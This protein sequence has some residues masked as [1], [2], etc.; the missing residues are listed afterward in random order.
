[1]SRFG[2]ERLMITKRKVA[3]GMLGLA[4]IATGL[5]DVWRASRDDVYYRSLA[6]E[7]VD[8]AGARTR[9]EQV[10]AL[11]DDLRARIAQEGLDPDRRPF[12]RPSARQTLESGR[13]YC[14][15]TCRA[16]IRL[17]GALGLRTQRVNLYGRHD[18]VVV[19]MFLGPTTSYLVDPHPDPVS[20]PYFDARDRTLDQVLLPPEPFAEDYSNINVRRV[21]VLG[22]FL[23]RVRTRQGWLTD[24]LESPMRMKAVLFIGAGGAILAALLVDSLLLLLY[25]RRLRGLSRRTASGEGASI[26]PPCARPRGSGG[27][28]PAHP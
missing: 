6:R 13:G 7:I 2:I 22:A 27:R 28:H 25:L 19:E 15:E 20:N 23:Q 1:M 12:L 10:R 11:R 18:T 17:A 5:I 9:R 3:V 24:L 4:L 16:F 14:G 8:S 21:P 26:P